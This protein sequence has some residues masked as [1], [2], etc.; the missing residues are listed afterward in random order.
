LLDYHRISCHYIYGS[1]A[2]KVFA[3]SYSPQDINCSDYT[4]EF[5]IT[6]DDGQTVKASNK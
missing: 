5:N 4:Y 2:V 6:V 1:K 3:L